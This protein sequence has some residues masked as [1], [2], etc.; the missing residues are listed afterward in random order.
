M[1]LDLRL[2]CDDCDDASLCPTRGAGRILYLVVVPAVVPVMVPAVAVVPVGPGAEV[3]LSWAQ[4]QSCNW[5]LVK[6]KKKMVVERDS[7]GAG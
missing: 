5:R 6:K 4:L 3:L 7:E 2:G 1:S